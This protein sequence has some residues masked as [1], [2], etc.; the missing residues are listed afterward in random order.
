MIYRF[1]LLERVLL[2]TNVIPHPMADAVMS[3]GL[4]SAL[5]VAVKLGI[6]DALSATPQSPKQIAA[7]QSLDERGTEAVLDC[8][9]AF[10]YAKKSDGN[11]S[12]T[13]RGQKYLSETSPDSF[14]DFIRFA[15]WL[16]RS[17]S[18]LEDT[19]RGKGKPAMNLDTMSDHEWGLFSRAM[20]NLSRTN[21]EEVTGKISLPDSAKRLIDL[22]GSHGLYSI[23]LCK[24][25][26][27]L[28]AVVADME[29]VRKYCDAMVAQ[30]GMQG[31]VTFM[32]IDFLKEDFG[33]G[34]DA[35]LAFNVIHGHDNE[36]N[37]R[38]VDKIHKSLNADGQLIILDQIKGT[39]GRTQLSRAT[40]SF[41]AINLLH[42]AHGNTY[43]FDEV[44]V[45]G[46]RAGFKRFDLRK[47][48]APGF[49]LIICK[50]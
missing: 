8:L 31:R 18:S 6:T 25:Y 5:C 27:G 42:Q 17:F 11:Y 45:W 1:S 19:I 36:L 15:D 20:I 33:N 10:G 37:N 4:S 2:A 9:E 12:F 23:H 32:P 26:P 43:T 16:H 48:H 41:M 44:K 29:P 35:A 21:V 40:T 49:A 47:L 24:K 3:M 14:L 46:A 38:F 13:N 28:T 39:G 34:Y 30:H 22:G 50:K 7:R